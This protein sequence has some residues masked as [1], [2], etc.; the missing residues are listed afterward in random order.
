MDIREDIATLEEK[1]EDLI[2]RLDVVY[3][4]LN[5]SDSKVEVNLTRKKVRAIVRSIAE[6]DIQIDLLSNL[7][8]SEKQIVEAQ[9]PKK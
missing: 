3:G 4:S 9:A 8:Q 6:I 2:E 5:S 1:R 7:L